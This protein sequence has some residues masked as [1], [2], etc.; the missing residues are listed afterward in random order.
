MRT[1]I[2]KIVRNARQSCGLTQNQLAQRL[3][4]TQQSISSIEAERSTPNLFTLLLIG[5]ALEMRLTVYY[6]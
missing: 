3:G 4:V 5:D 2:G 1:G 6:K